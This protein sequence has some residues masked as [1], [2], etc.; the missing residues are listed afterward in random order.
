MQLCCKSCIFATQFKGAA[1]LVGI[2]GQSDTHLAKPVH[3][4]M[5][6]LFFQNLRSWQSLGMWASL[7]C[8]IHCLAMPV[9]LAFAAFYGVQLSEHSPYE[10]PILFGA[11]LFAL[12][13]VGGQYKYHRNWYPLLLL[14]VGVALLFVSLAAHI[15][16]LFLPVSALLAAAQL[17]N[18]Y[19]YHRL[20]CSNP[21]HQH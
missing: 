16:T 2:A 17:L 4:Y 14:A 6:R 10:L 9:V 5:M 21:H 11:T 15:H 12:V 13:L 19:L 3:F 1:S 8:A 7:L 20:S 18:S